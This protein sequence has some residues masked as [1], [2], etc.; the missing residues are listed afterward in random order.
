ML[1]KNGVKVSF[2]SDKIIMIRNGNFVGKGYCNQGFFILNVIEIMNENASSS[3]F[4]VYSIDLWYTR[5]GLVN[6]SYV[7][8]MNQLGLITSNNNPCTQKC[9]VY[10]ES[11]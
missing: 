6:F 10:A 2:E 8:K 4:F 11:K 1:G 5:L 7:K 3:T 9:D